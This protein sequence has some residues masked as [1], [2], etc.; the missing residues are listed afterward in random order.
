VADGKV[1]YVALDWVPRHCVV[2]DGFRKGHPVDLYD[3]QLRYLAA[4]YSVRPDVEWHAD[5]P[6][7][8]PAFV[9]RRALLVGPQ[10]VGKSPFTA[11]H[12]C[13]EGVGPVLFA[14]WASGGEEYRCADHGCSCGWVYTYEAGEPM[15]MPW[16]TALIQLTA[17]SEDQTDNIYDALRPMVDDGPLHDLIPKTGEAFIR[18]PSGGRIDTVTASEQSRLGQRTTFVAQ[19]EVGLWT[20]RNKMTRV[21]DAQYRNLAG[22]GGRASLES[23]AWDPAQ[24]SVAQREFESASSDVYRQFDR[25]PKSLRTAATWTWTRSRRRRPTWPRATS[26]RPSV[27]SATGWTPARAAPSTSISSAAWRPPNRSSSTMAR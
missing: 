13:L 6:I 2:P 5:R 3:F 7:L 8:G 9:Y 21:A 14:G 16:P 27:S 17:F 19:T 12:V 26:R 25:P 18:L 10:K 11:A 4:F 24:Q 22:M 23:N 15:G 20:P 1:L